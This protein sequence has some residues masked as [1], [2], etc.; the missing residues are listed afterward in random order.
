MQ[1]MA[2]KAKLITQYN[3]GKGTSKMKLL[4]I[5]EVSILKTIRFN[6]KYF[7]I[8]KGFF[9]PV[10]VSK[11][12]VLQNL[13]G[14]ITFQGLKCNKKTTAT[15]K[16][17]FKSLGILNR[18][19]KL[20]WDNTGNVVFFGK[21]SLSKGVK[22]S[23]RGKIVFGNNFI[24]TGNTS[25]ICFKE[26]RF[27]DNCLVSWDGLIMDTDFHKIISL[28]SGKVVNENKR[29][30][31]GNNVWMG[32]RVTILKGTTIPNDSIIAAGSIIACEVEGT[33]KIIGQN[34]KKL[35]EHVTWDY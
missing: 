25:F 33:N 22:L 9:L 17:G 29:V 18:S 31:V 6:Y 35:K 5:F 7:G 12:V 16:L 3:V 10:L 1:N 15:I 14:S 32:A 8:K 30:L 11:S 27:G 28:G 4:K 34:G 23:N 21:C 2:L 20:I 13:S 19:D 24:C 26:V